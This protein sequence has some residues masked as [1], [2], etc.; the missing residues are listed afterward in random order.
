MKN[1]LDDDKHEQARYA[2]FKKCE[3]LAGHNEAISGYAVAFVL[4]DVVGQLAELNKNFG[5]L[6]ALIVD[7]IMAMP[8]KDPE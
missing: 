2:L 3:V 5:S 6:N 7:L 8:D 4:F 1:M